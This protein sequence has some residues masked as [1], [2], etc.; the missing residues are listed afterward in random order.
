MIIDAET[1]KDL[2]EFKNLTVEELQSKLNAIEDLIRN[3][4][5]NNF[6]NRHIRF[7]WGEVL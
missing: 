3:Y 2:D 6:Q 1:I 5:H 7:D 4:T